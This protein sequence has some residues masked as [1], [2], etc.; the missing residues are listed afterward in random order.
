MNPLILG[1][2]GVMDPINVL[3]CSVRPDKI[4]IIFV[5]VRGTEKSNDS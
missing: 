5:K 4:L 3:L 2:Q 1:N